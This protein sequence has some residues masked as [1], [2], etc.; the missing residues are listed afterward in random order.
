VITV[1]F[2]VTQF[3]ED[4]TEDSFIKRADDAMYLAKKKGRNRVE[5]NA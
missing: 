1:S 2:G 5:V 3:R 4:D